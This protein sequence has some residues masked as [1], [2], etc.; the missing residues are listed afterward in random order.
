MAEIA[1]RA[2]TV[3]LPIRSRSIGYGRRDPG[4][5]L[6]RGGG[7]A[8]AG[9]CLPVSDAYPKVNLTNCD[10]EP[11]HIPGAIQPVGFL[12][13]LSREWIVTRV[14]ANSAEFVGLA[15]EAIIGRP[16]TDVFTPTAIHNLR[17]R[18][19]MLRGPDAVERL[20]G[21]S[22]TENG[23]PRDCAIH[24]SGDEVVI[25]ADPSSEDQGAETGVV[26]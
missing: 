10:R 11:I 1:G 4:L 2:G 19:A 6:L 13:A 26:R 18:L 22:L 16:V 21:A 17:N 12:V 20:F 25:E 15:P 5:R 24:M 7:E 14:S 9:D 3:T 8:P 23:T